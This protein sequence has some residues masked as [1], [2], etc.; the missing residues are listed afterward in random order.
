MKNLQTVLIEKLHIDKNVKLV[1]LTFPDSESNHGTINGMNWILSPGMPD[2]HYTFFADYIK[3]ILKTCVLS[4]NQRNFLENFLSDLKNI[5]YQDWSYKCTVINGKAPYFQ[6]AKCIG[7]ICQWALKDP[8]ITIPRKNKLNKLLRENP[9][10]SDT[11]L[12]WGYDT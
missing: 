4:D 8:K 7:D 10:I 5:K 11:T 6:R 1:K 2:G 12:G 3:K 9:S